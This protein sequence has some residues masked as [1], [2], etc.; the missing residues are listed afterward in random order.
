MAQYIDSFFLLYTKL[1]NFGKKAVHGEF[2]RIRTKTSK[3][4]VVFFNYY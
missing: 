4:F 3:F 2:T 1:F